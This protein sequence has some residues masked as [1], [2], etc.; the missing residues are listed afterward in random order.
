[1]SI[2]FL[3]SASI[4]SVYLVF[5]AAKKFLP[6]KICAICA[7]V[8]LTW[9]GLL[10]GYFLNWHNNTLIIGILMGGSVVGLMYKTGNYFYTNQ[11]KNFWLARLLIIVFG[12]L[13]VNFIITK[14]RGAFSTVIILAIISGFVFLFFVKDKK[15]PALADD[16]AKKT[17]QK[18]MEHCCD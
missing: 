6:A 18:N 11:L 3:T 7:A 8:S 17:L 13:S 14:Q 10:I 4:I 15:S 1:M 5:T 12:F 2:I 9:T 16:S